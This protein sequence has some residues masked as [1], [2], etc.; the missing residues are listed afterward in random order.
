MILS[1][2]RDLLRRR[3]RDTEEE[4]W[5]DGQLNSIINLAI[6]RVQLRVMRVNPEAELTVWRANLVSG[7]QYYN[8]PAGA[9]NFIEVAMKDSDAA[10]GYRPLTRSDYF[11]NRDRTE[12]SG[13]ILGTYYSLFA[14]KVFVAPAPTSDVTDGLQF[15]GVPALSA[16]DD[17]DVLP[18]H[19]ALHFAVVLYAE[20]I[21]KGETDEAK[22]EIR[23]ELN[24][25]DAD[26]TTLYSYG[27][28][29]ESISLDID[30]EY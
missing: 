5:T 22:A 6:L 26:I 15:I 28:L 17:A 11:R 30:K 29:A 1:D 20:I 18:L 25:V 24:A 8:K 19:L 4:I 9:T 14:N 13:D 10:T 21:A 2:A 27:G 23:E 16:G 7:Q 12:P 3:L